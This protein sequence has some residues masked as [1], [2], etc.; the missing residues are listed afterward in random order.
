MILYKY[1][2][3]S[4]AR[5]MIESSALGFSRVNDLNDPFESSSLLFEEDSSLTSK[6]IAMGLKNRLSTK[7]GVL[8][9][10]RQPLNS[11]MWSHY[12]D[13]HKGVVIGIDVDLADLN[14]SETSVIP[15]HYGDV[16]YTATQPANPI[17]FSDFNRLMLE[18]FELERFEAHSSNLLA[19]SYLYKSLEWAYEEEVRVVK[20][21]RSSTK[22]SIPKTKECEYSN[23]Q[24]DWNKITI[25]GRPI[26]CLKIPEKSFC[27]VYLGHHI[28]KNVSERGLEKD[29]LVE[30]LESWSSR[31]IQILKCE[32]EYNSWSLTSN[33]LEKFS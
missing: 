2:S 17:V 7:F 27:K 5:A 11:L 9:L 22:V 26:H 29:E 14:S 6:Q 31:G 15:S 30:I 25:D 8:S 21:I 32:P 18:D 24:G 4:G 12:G 1:V 3:L 23:N 10:T 20:D 19:R 33:A 13:S 28:W 16:R